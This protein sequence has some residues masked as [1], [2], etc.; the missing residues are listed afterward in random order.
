MS[1]LLF[2]RRFLGDL[3]GLDASQVVRSLQT[4]CLDDVLRP[5]V[6]ISTG[7]LVNG[8]TGAHS[9]G[10]R[11][12]QQFAF[13]TGPASDLGHI[14]NIANRK[15]TA[16]IK[17][18]DRKHLAGVDV[19][20]SCQAIYSF[21]ALYCPGKRTSYRHHGRCGWVGWGLRWRGGGWHLGDHYFCA[22]RVLND[23]GGHV[24]VF[25]DC[26]RGHGGVDNLLVNRQ[27]SAN[28]VNHNGGYLRGL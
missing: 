1:L 4:I 5:H 16:C 13:T 18:V 14:E 2:Y 28:L 10:I 6:A 3:Q 24:K 7:Y 15:H 25:N 23:L 19:E 11:V 21:T 8:F 12:G 22:L 20:P 26:L 9:P 17:I 27:G